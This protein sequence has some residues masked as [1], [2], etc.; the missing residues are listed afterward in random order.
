MKSDLKSENVGGGPSMAVGG[1][2]SARSAVSQ[3]AIVFMSA[4]DTENGQTE[5]GNEAHHTHC[6]KSAIQLLRENVPVQD[7]AASS[8][9]LYKCTRNIEDRS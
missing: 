1:P 6:D 2:F 9:S 7:V 8:K 4:T 5:V 3:V